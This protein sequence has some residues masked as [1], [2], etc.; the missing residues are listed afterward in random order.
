MVSNG[1]IR[2]RKLDKR[3]KGHGMFSH[4]INNDRYMWHE[5]QTW[6]SNKFGPVSGQNRKLKIFY[7]DKWGIC[8]H[9]NSKKYP[10]IYFTNEKYLS[11][12]LMAWG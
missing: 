10:D 5:Y 6:L 3:F 7:N 12:F 4:T 1:T 2:V 11:W 9:I 8:Y